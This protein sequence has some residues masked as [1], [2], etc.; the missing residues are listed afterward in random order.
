ML[1][2]PPARRPCASSSPCSQ[3]SLVVAPAAQAADTPFT[4]RYAQTMR[5]SIEAVGNQLL[6]CPTSANCT[7]ARNRTGSTA[8]MNNNYNMGYV[9]IDGD[10]VH[11]QLVDGD[12]LPA[13]RRDRHLGRPLLGRRHGG[14]HRRLGRSQRRQPRHRELQ[15]RR[16]RLPDGHRQRAPTC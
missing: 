12:A 4:Q 10:G 15:G 7:N 6:T 2:V 14:R 11:G 9:D 3:G 13:R 8:T 5:G 16:G 1:G